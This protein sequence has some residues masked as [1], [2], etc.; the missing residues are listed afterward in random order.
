[1]G[2][3]PLSSSAS[4]SITIQL[5][6]PNSISFVQPGGYFF[7]ISENVPSGAIVG[8]VELAP[9][10]DHVIQFIVFSDNTT[11][12]QLVR[13]AGEVR[14]QIQ[15]LN[16]FDYEARQSYIFRIEARVLNSTVLPPVN[17]RTSVIVTV[18]VIDTND[19]QPV[20]VNFPSTLAYLENRTREEMV[21]DFSASDADSGMN[22][23]IEYQILNQDIQSK[24]RIDSATGELFV[25]ARVDREERQNY[26]II[27]QAMDRGTP[28]H[29]VQSTT[30][31]T[32]LDVND[33]VPR[34]TNGFSM[35]V[36]ER[37]QP[38]LQ[39]TQFMGVDPDLGSN[40]TFQFFAVAGGS[41]PD[42]GISVVTIHTNGSVQ[43]ARELDYEQV[44]TYT[45]HVRIADQGIPPLQFTYTNITLQ[46][47][48]EPD[49]TPQFIIPGGA[50]IYSNTTLPRLGNGDILALVRAMDA[51]P[52]DVISYEI[53]SI[54]VEGNN[55]MQPDFRIDS[56]TGRIYNSGVRN[57]TPE[58]NFTIN[59]VAYDNSRF[60]LSVGAQVKIMVRPERLQFTQANY[61][62]QL[63]EDASIRSE[64]FRVP[65]QPLSASSLVRYRINVDQPAGQTRVF[66][67]D[68]Q[69]QSEAIIRLAQEID[70]E[71]IENYTF[72][73]TAQRVGESDV[74][75][76]VFI[77]VTDVNDSPPQFLD[78]PNSVI[79]VSESTT[80][81][82]RISKVNATDPDSGENARLRYTFRS[83]GPGFPF[84]ID[85]NTGDIVVSGTLDYELI[86]SYPVTVDVSDSGATQISRSQVY[87]IQIV[88]ENDN[89]PQ[90]STGNYF[91][92]IYAGA[93]PGD[94]V[95]H[96]QIQVTD[97]DDPSSVQPIT[98]EVSF[99][100][101]STRSDYVFEVESDAPHRI[102]IIDLPQQDPDTESQ[103]LE[104]IVVARD[105]RHASSVR[106]FISVFTYSNLI[107]FQF[108]GTTTAQLLDCSGLLSS[109]CGFLRALAI[110]TQTQTHTSTPV[111]F[112]N[113]SIQSSPES[114]L[115]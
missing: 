81:L 47:I 5:P 30:T 95:L 1:M 37:V 44:Q 6:V 48:D 38:P 14:A 106:L 74:T 101:D 82:V 90:F 22:S 2:I 68:G 31:F 25:S 32:L 35:S 52:G 8:M 59:V 42:V 17:L 50:P 108:S 9:V 53:G 12:F 111:T 45:I 46:V 79:L 104:L 84:R 13:T 49:N 51:D 21:H 91:G 20:F 26:Q 71:R 113:Y 102:R 56:S 41:I 98:F 69:G 54:A 61:T 115:E 100:V 63:S 83:S 78:P 65:L 10:P 7:N 23:V 57:L 3:P 77:N 18:I 96:T 58:A 94:Y 85:R 29:S 43:L 92:E 110:E 103:L 72:S 87:T 80:S 105:E 86:S 112:Y 27:I 73:I 64:V 60:N 107:S 67:V 34:M 109:I 4:I 88:N 33:N 40:G 114:Q 15:S 66:S 19:N 70:R 16:L 97:P 89:I 62:V 93:S 76:T 24:F 55:G 36:R 11:D 99:A 28:R 75:A 39:L